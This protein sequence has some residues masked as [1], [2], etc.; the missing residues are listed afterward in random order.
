MVVDDLD[1]FGIVSRPVK[2]EPELIVHSKA[3]LARTIAL[4]LLQPIRRWRAEVLE[5]S[6]H[7]EL[8]QL[9]Q[10]R[11]LDVRKARYAPE[12]EQRFGVRAFE[13]LDRHRL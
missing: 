1:V 10:R 9:S 3:P 8:L 13:S 11:A 12:A 4:Q 6:R 5:A 2:A 7:V